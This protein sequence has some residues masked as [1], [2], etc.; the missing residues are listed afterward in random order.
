M[1]VATIDGKEY[2][3][4]FIDKLVLPIIHDDSAKIAAIRTAK[5]DTIESLA[6]EFKESIE[7]SSPDIIW[8]RWLTGGSTYVAFKSSGDSRFA[9]PRSAKGDGGRYRQV[10]H[11]RYG[12]PG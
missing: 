7:K 4:P 1:A 12:V 10:C 11:S 3:L 6:P 8:H 9:R 5:L 2:Q